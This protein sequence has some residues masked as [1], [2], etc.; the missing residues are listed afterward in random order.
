MSQ[1]KR[2]AVFTAMTA[3]ALTGGAMADT[4]PPENNLQSRLTELEQRDVQNSEMINALRAE[5]HALR[6][7]QD[8]S[9]LTEQR[10]EEIRSLV[11]D[12]LADAD[13]RASML[14]SNM[15]RGAGTM[16]FIWGVTM[17]TS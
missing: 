8:D 1:M 11:H 16:G 4:N 15:G 17:A 3:I 5:V 14:G 13:T 12:V 7:G 6:N 10:S 9:W 2:S